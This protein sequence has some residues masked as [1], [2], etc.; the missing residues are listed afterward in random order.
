M[1]EQIRN[2]LSNIYAMQIY[3]SIKLIGYLKQSLSDSDR[4]FAYTFI[5]ELVGLVIFVE[6]G[7][8]QQNSVFVSVSDVIFVEIFPKLS[9][10]FCIKKI[11][12]LSIFEAWKLCF[13]FIFIFFVFLSFAIVFVVVFFLRSSFNFFVYLPQFTL[14]FRSVSWCV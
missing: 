9:F 11:E 5:H 4:L 13:E 12:H 6:V 1:I 10:I 3:K 7:D 2:F 14:L 8:K